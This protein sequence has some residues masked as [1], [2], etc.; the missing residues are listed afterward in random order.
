MLRNLRTCSIPHNWFNCFLSPKLLHFLL[1]TNEAI[2]ITLI[3]HPNNKETMI[4]SGPREYMLLIAIT[5]SPLRSTWSPS[6]LLM[7]L[8]LAF[9][10]KSSFYQGRLNPKQQLTQLTRKK[11]TRKSCTN[12]EI[13]CLW[14][15]QVILLKIVIRFKLPQ[16]YLLILQNDSP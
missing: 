15:N 5:V 6:K 14:S 3:L 16:P 11:G 10:K 9:Q 8:K 13:T 7:L 12:V 2:V 1:Y 4:S